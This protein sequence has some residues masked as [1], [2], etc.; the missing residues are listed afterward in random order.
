MQEVEK[1]I[2]VPPFLKGGTLV[3]KYVDSKAKSLNFH[4]GYN[5]SHSI[6]TE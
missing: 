2:D 4:V 1:H 5:L 6:L 3:L